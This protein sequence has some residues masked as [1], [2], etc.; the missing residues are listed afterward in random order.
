[1]GRDHGPIALDRDE[2]SADEPAVTPD[3]ARPFPSW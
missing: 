1:L 3:H 2:V